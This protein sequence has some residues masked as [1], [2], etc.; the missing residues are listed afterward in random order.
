M[1]VEDYQRLKREYEAKKKLKDRNEIA[2]ENLH[3]KLKEELGCKSLEDA[4]S[5]LARLRRSL[6]KEEKEWDALLEEYDR[7]N[8]GEA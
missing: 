8:R 3:K 4:E 6:Q 1:N 7:I 2:S 5:T